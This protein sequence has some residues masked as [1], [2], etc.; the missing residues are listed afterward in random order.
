MMELLATEARQI[1]LSLSQAHLAAFEAYYR[2]LA[3]WNH[4][5]NLT[6]IVGYEQVQVKH[7]LDSLTCILAFPGITAAQ[8]VPDAI[9]LLQR[10]CELRCA[11]V[12][13]GAGF[14]GIPLKIIFPGMHLTLIES[15]HKKAVFLEHITRLLRLDRVQVIASRAEEVGQSP[16]TREQYDLVLARAVASMNV[17]AEY[18]LPLL[19]MGG[20][21]IAQK[22]EG[23]EAELDAARNALTLLGGKVAA[24][25]SYKL[26]LV[27][28]TRYLVAVDKVAA[29][30]R[31]YPRRPGV[32]SKKPL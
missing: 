15:T 18:C 28:E 12:G 22:G 31:Q 32:P 13:S 7:F 21:W 1:G 16:N 5:F 27:D 11:D 3:V 24:L 9:P 20:R 6:T 25:K 26:S 29:T 8:E 14:P 10:D 30:P 19:N 2:E 17:L 4:R 23:I